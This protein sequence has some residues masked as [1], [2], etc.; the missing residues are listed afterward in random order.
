LIF[1]SLPKKIFFNGWD[2]YCNKKPPVI[3]L[4]L[5]S[6]SAFDF[7]LSFGEKRPSKQAPAVWC[8]DCHDNLIVVGCRNGRLEVSFSPHTF[9]FLFSSSISGLGWIF[10]PVEIYSP[11][12][13]SWNHCCLFCRQ[14]VRIQF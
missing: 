3:V 7:D 8:L 11:P 1:I 12:F 9:S 6:D 2:Y 4:V 10:W 13:P 5:V 14:Q